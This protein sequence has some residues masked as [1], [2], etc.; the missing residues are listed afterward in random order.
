LK[1]TLVKEMNFY[2]S[3]N[4]S[5]LKGTK[6]GNYLF[7]LLE[8]KTISGPIGHHMINGTN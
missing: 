6:Q 1:L 3:L 8:R 5:A 7:P 2:V 4:D